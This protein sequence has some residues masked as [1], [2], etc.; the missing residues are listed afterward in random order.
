MFIPRGMFIDE[1]MFRNDP[2]VRAKH[3]PSIKKVIFNDPATIVIWGD[4]SKT[5]VKCQEGDT[6]D[7]EKGLALCIAK[8][9][10]G[11]KGNFN[12]VF[13][14][15]I[16]EDKIEFPEWCGEDADCTEC[17]YGYETGCKLV[18]QKIGQTEKENQGPE[19]DIEV[20]KIGTRIKIIDAG[21]GAYGV[22][23]NIGVVTNK[24][25]TDGLLETDPGYNVDI[26]CKVWRINP[27]ADVEEV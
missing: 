1:D 5:V 10:L 13:K 24:R 17:P 19:D 27:D 11:N 22:N 21:N 23:G 18:D 26:G 14:K 25:N 6:Y 16:P 7:A 8:K 20:P 15:W 2:F 4:N 9:Y 3:N 12:E